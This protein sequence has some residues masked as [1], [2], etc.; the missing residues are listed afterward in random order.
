MQFIRQFCNNDDMLLKFFRKWVYSR[1]IPLVKLSLLEDDREYDK[2]EFKKVV[3]SIKQLGEEPDT[4]FIFPLKLRVTTNQESST[5]SVIIKE[6]EQRF[7][8]TR[9]STIRTIDIMD[10]V[11]FIKE[12][13]QPSSSRFRYK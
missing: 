12:K 5:E 6:N 13:K 4:D 10:D 8:I 7:V 3:I 2:K 9:E 11:A 1:A